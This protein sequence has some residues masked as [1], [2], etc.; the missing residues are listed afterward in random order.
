MVCQLCFRPAEGYRKR[1]SAPPYG[2]MRPGKSR[3]LSIVH[4]EL[5]H[6]LVLFKT[7]KDV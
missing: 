4:F 2:P 1:R 3:C 5:A 7:V 6:S